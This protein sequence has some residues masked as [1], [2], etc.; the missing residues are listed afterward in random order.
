MVSTV[1]QEAEYRKFNPI[2]T[3]LFAFLSG[4]LLSRIEAMPGSPEKPLS[5]LGRLSYES[6]W[7]SKVLPYV[8][9]DSTGTAIMPE[10]T[11]REISEAT[12][13]EVHDVVAT[14][15]QLSSGVQLHPT[16]GR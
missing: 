14:L 5:D 1:C 13:M 4:Y 11:I 9:S 2:G 3:S 12:G 10:L 16:D 8:L 6:Y 7:R 15:Q